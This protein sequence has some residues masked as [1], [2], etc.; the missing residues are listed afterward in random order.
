[1]MEYKILFISLLH[2]FGLSF[3]QITIKPR[4]TA[5]L[6]HTQTLSYKFTMHIVTRDAVQH[7]GSGT[8][9]QSYAISLM[10]EGIEQAINA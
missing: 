3:T 6:G 2:L 10:L 4:H 8:S 1:M 5:S 7:D 9:I